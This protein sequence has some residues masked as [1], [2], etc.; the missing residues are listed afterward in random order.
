MRNEMPR[1]TAPPR[2]SG[3]GYT[4][5]VPTGERTAAATTTC[6]EHKLSGDIFRQ[7]PDGGGNAGIAD[8]VGDVSIEVYAD[9]DD[10]AVLTGPSGGGTAGPTYNGV[11]QLPGFTAA[12]P[13]RIVYNSKGASV[14]RHVWT[15]SAGAQD[16][17]DDSL[18]IVSRTTNAILH[19]A[20]VS[21]PPGAR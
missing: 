21:S 11:T 5:P 8:F 10:I 13:S 18:Y 14:P 19:Y 4:V 17:R 9:G 16:H 2:I 15:M 3:A 1:F 7:M 12:L 20:I 6:S